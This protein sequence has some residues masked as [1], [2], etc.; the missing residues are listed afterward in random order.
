MLAV[1][2]MTAQS[3][4]T[5]NRSTSWLW[6]AV[7]TAIAASLTYFAWLRWDRQRDINPVTQESTG[8]YE[9]WQVIGVALVLALLAG[10]V[11][12]KGHPIVAVVV[13]SLTFTTCWSF[14]AATDPNVVGANLWPIGAVMVLVGCL[15]G[16]GSLAGAIRAVRSS[17]RDWRSPS[18]RRSAA[19]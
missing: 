8:P 4:Q 18:Q 5:S 17:Q 19:P 3:A 1:V 15:S 12:W 2:D 13:I 7:A 10:I 14:G 11:A 6:A 9:V 16:T